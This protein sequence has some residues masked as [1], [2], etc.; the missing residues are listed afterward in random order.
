MNIPLLH[1]SNSI[2]PNTPQYDINVCYINDQYP[3]NT[4]FVMSILR[5]YSINTTS[6]RLQYYKNTTML[7][8]ITAQYY[9]FQYCCNTTSILPKYYINTP[10]CFPILQQYYL[11]TTLLPFQYPKHPF[12]YYTWSNTTQY[13]QYN[14]ILH[15]GSILHSA[16]TT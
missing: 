12:Q 11:N 6:I 13:Y 15:T 5:Q 1:T 16:N 10:Y 2:H 7:C 14:S 4:T 9:S 3:S 8:S